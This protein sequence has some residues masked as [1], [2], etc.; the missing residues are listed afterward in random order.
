MSGRDGGGA[1]E[2]E[3][4]VRRNHMR[5]LSAYARFLVRAPGCFVIA[6]CLVLQTAIMLTGA[7]GLNILLQNKT[8][9]EIHS[10]TISHIDNW[11][12]IEYLAHIGHLRVNEFEL[13]PINISSSRYSYGLFLEIQLENG[14][15]EHRRVSTF[16]SSL[17]RGWVRITLDADFSVESFDATAIAVIPFSAL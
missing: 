11:V 8:G 17:D 15:V 5:R 3:Y 6:V 14:V 12:N 4:R 16:L 7:N 1:G 13:V 9:R 10:V 2:R